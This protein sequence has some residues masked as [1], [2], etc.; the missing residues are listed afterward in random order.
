VEGL[1]WSLCSIILLLTPVRSEVFHA[2]TSLFLSKNE[3]NSV[4]SSTV[5]S[6]E[7]ITILPGTLGSRGTFP[8]SYSGSMAIFLVML[9]SILGVLMSCWPP[10]SSSCKQFTFMCSGAKPCSIFL[11]SF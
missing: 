7:I 4:S 8:V 6:W 1:T 2:K 9:A 3:S 10:P 5:R 11:T